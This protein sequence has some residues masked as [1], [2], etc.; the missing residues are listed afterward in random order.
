[1]FRCGAATLSSPRPR[2][3]LRHRS[4]DARVIALTL[5]GSP[6]LRRDDG[7]PVDALLAQPRPLALVAY[8]GAA[9][10]S[11]GQFHRRDVLVDLFWS[12]SGQEQAR[13]NLRRLVHIVR[14]ELGSDVIESR[15]DEELRLSPT[16]V[17]SDVAQFEDALARGRLARAD[18]L[19]RA[20]L[21]HGF[22]IPGAPS[23]QFDQWLAARRLHYSEAAA[24]TAWQL[25]VR[26][27][28]SENVT[29]AVRL[30]RRAARLARYDE[31]RLRRAMELLVRAGDHGAAIM[32]YE[33]LRSSLAELDAQPSPE[34]RALVERLR[35]RVR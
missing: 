3:C 6:D 9:G 27:E 33:E 17:Q 35:L 14:G 15:G 20:P 19:Y 5:F 13:R 30:A 1:V 28:H 25:A 32:L 24:E 21:L 16:L 22:S 23:P 18:E 34:T 10:P 7:A 4:T 29:E 2:R 31:R 11:P 26:L 12:E 8:L